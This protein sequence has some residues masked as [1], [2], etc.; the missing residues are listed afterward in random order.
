VNG[1][2]KRAPVFKTGWGSWDADHPEEERRDTDPS[3]FDGPSWVYDLYR[4]ET[5]SATAAIPA[6]RTQF[7]A[8]AVPALSLPVGANETAAMEDR[9]YNMPDLFADKAHWPRAKP[10]NI[11]RWEHSD[12][13]NVAYLYMTKFYDKLVSISQP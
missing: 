12:M 3:H 13:R 5:G 8:E 6:N 7:L 2:L 10:N 4:D 11:P 1:E 9:N